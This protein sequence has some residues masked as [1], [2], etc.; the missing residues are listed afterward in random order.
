MIMMM[1]KWKN[2]IIL[3][4]ILFLVGC[5]SNIPKEN[6]DYL[7]LKGSNLKKSEE[8][9]KA[10]DV[11][12]LALKEDN[13]NLILLEEMGD[14]YT[15]LGDYSEGIKYYKKALKLNPSKESIIKNLSYVY[16][17]EKDYKNS[18]KYIDELYE[19][20]L[21]LESKKLK[22]FLLIKNHK[23]KE[24]KDYLNRL[25]KEINSFDEVYYKNYTEFLE[26]NNFNDDLVKVLN[27]ISNKYY[28]NPKAMT[29]YF[30]EK[31]KI[32]HNYNDLEK[33]IKRYIVSGDA[34]TEIYIL[35]AEIENKLKK[36]EEEKMILKF[37]SPVEN[38]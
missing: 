36:F 9:S 15:K 34:E 22:G 29:F 8:Y 17:L 31:E 20:E 35:L 37:V 27:D 13:K 16:F 3:L 12:K 4:G 21:D 28:D 7:I 10:L 5:S 33:E 23:T 24:A 30:L 6:S 2:N 18:L 14:T 1:K 11:Y 32:C 25:E 19:N 26:K 38:K